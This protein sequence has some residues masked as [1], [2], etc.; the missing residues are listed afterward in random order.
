MKEDNDAS[1]PS[2]RRT[3]NH[4]SRGQPGPGWTV[5]LRRQPARLIGGQPQGGYT[6]LFELICC[7]CG[8]DP[9]RDY[10]EVAPELQQIRGPYPIAAGIGAY[11]KHIQ[12]HMRHPG[13]RGE[14]PKAW[15][16]S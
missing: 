2:T 8:D 7:H 5:V 10:H 3:G 9:D 6:E 4:A 11:E 13:P 12:H 1:P 14:T 16:N 15:P